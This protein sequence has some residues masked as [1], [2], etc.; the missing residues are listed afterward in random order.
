MGD[1]LMS[2]TSP[3]EMMDEINLNGVTSN[4]GN[5][6]SDDEVV[7][8]DDDD[9]IDNNNSYNTSVSN[10]NNPFIE[11]NIINDIDFKMSDSDKDSASR[12]GTTHEELFAD[13]PMPEW[14]NPFLD[15]ENTPSVDVSNSLD[16]PVGPS[17]DNGAVPS[18]FEEDV[19]FVGAELEGSEKVPGDE[20]EKIDDNGT[21]LNDFNDTN[22]WRV[23]QEVSVSE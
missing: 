16:T 3:S 13:R 8:G 12:S 1:E 17:L 22:Y 19:E 7:V 5:S 21:E 20:K 23:D 11:D 15:Y 4:G 10:P 2:A 9:L 6:S 14:V 18:L